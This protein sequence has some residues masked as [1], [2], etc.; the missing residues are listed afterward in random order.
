MS[1]NYEKLNP[2]LDAIEILQI[3]GIYDNKIKKTYEGFR[4]NCP[5]HG[6]DKRF[7][8]TIN[9]KTNQYK[10]HNS[11]CEA[12]GDLIGLYANLKNIKNSDAARELSNLFQ[13][14]N[15]AIMN[16]ELTS[17]KDSIIPAQATTLPENNIKRIYE[18]AEKKGTNP[19]LEE[20]NVNS[21]SELRYGNDEKGFPSIIVPFKNLENDELQTLQYVNANEGGKNFATGH[22]PKGAAFISGDKEK[23]KTL[24]VAEGLAT[25]LTIKQAVEQTVELNTNLCSFI[26][27]GSATN[28]TPC[29]KILKTRYPEKKIII[30]LDNDEAGKKI[31]KD[32]ESLSDLIFCEPDFTNIDVN[33][34][35]TDFND[36]FLHT[37]I[38]NVAK[39]LKKSIQPDES[40]QSSQIDKLSEYHIKNILKSSDY[41]SKLE[42]RNLYFK[43]NKKPKISGIETGYSKLDDCIGGFQPEHLIILG[44]RTGVGKSWVALNFIKN[45]SIVQQ[46]P[47]VLF[48]LEMSE[49]Q[50]IDRLIQLVSGISVA[51]IKSGSFNDE[52][53]DKIKEAY[54]KIEKSNLIIID[55]PENSLLKNLI[56]KI[57]SLVDKFKIE[58]VIID[59][60]G[61][62]KTSSKGSDNRVTEMGS[63]V[64]ELKLIA[65][66]HKIP[67][68]GLAQLNREAE[69][70]D[71]PKLSHLRESGAIEQDAD[72]VMLLYRHDYLNQE[73]SSKTLDIIIEK[74]RDGINGT[75]KFNYGDYWDL[76][77]IKDL[78][79]QT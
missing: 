76:F 50:L 79:K 37:D 7:S 39:Q 77:M 27:C 58:F 1:I 64:R 68:M 61:L 21:V 12:K 2:L 16:Q 48:S 65:K 66:K 5:I 4:I 25:I 23:A 51:K 62:I 52:E 9:I 8:L 31:S 32:L 3:A 33:D 43:E 11:S 36:L 49:L 60:I 19:Y 15:E 34:K 29:V 72:I 22:S 71:K 6:G 73:P 17:K 46:K 45:I 42:E 56:D 10:C 69:G 47:I 20:K 53:Y 54:S 30:C 78:N 75:I 63:I 44:A 41:L 14:N 55:N 18:S 57:N 38:E 35:P 40:L 26:S 24:Y 28:I 74:N 67:L 70:N 13:H 59:H